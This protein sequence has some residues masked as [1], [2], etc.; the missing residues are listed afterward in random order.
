[1]IQGKKQGAVLISGVVLLWAATI[2][3]SVFAIRQLKKIEGELE[4]IDIE[5][6]RLAQT[7]A[8]VDIL[9]LESA[10]MLRR[11]MGLLGDEVAD[12]IL[13]LREK[14]RTLADLLDQQASEIKSLGNL[15]GELAAQQRADLSQEV[16]EMRDLI[17]RLQKSHA[18]YLILIRRGIISEQGS[19]RVV[20]GGIV[21]QLGRHEAELDELVDRVSIGVK[22][23]V[24]RSLALSAG[25]KHASYMEMLV[26]AAMIV[27][28]GFMLVLSI[29]RMQ[30]RLI[31]T[32]NLA[33]VGKMAVALR[34][35]INNP[36]AAI[37]GNSF[38]LRHEG[39]LSEEQRRQTVTAI[40]ESAQ[41]ISSV[42]KRLSEMKEVSITDHLGGVEMLDISKGK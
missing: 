31:E 3:L 14:P 37:V 39:E 15:V 22:A 32:E 11:F 41:R 36:L 38:L 24:Q 34:H 5:A 28:F 4:L 13:R 29:M 30:R 21:D 42:V 18:A 35:E 33:L 20:P 8:R 17:T 12:P 16:S 19:L 7:V 26:I 40:E 6:T 10:I 1:M 25:Y 23:L 27:L 2:V 9:H